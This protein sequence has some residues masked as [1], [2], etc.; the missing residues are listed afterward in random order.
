MALSHLPYAV[1]LA[2]SEHVSGPLEVSQI[3]WGDGT[4]S[5]DTFM[6]CPGSAS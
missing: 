4:C 5:L 1:S 3:P 6:V 2:S